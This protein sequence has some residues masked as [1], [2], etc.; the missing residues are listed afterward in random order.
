MAVR[1]Y[2]YILQTEE[3]LQQGLYSTE[4]AERGNY[5]GYGPQYDRHRAAEKSGRGKAE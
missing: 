5:T 1:W 2:L 4:E 3:I